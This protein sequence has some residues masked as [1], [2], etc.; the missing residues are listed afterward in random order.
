MVHAHVG[1][2]RGRDGYILYVCTNDTHPLTPHPNQPTTSYVPSV[3][4]GF[5]PIQDI[6]G[7]DVVER[8]VAFT[9]QKGIAYDPR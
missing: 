1:R 2:T 5:L 8:P 4:G 9:P 7:V 3:R 6:T